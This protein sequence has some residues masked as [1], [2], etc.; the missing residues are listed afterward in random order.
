M[1]K[2]RDG[3]FQEQ[4]K[5]PVIERITQLVRRHRSRSA[6]ARAWGININTLNSY[7]KNEL[8]PPMPRDNLLAQIATYEGVS[9]EWLRSGGVESPETPETPEKNDTLSQMLTF[10][11]ADERQQLA[12]TLARK[13]VETVL[14]LLDEDNIELLRLDKVIKE[15]ILGKQPQTPEEADQNDQKAR[16]CDSSQEERSASKSLAPDRKQA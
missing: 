14:Y 1:R 15:K 8:E 7:Y 16:E 10:L 9:L 13:G 4:G 6:A 2:E 11:T 3:S 5:K 12:A